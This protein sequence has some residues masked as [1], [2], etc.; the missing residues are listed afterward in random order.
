MAVLLLPVDRLPDHAFMTASQ[1]VRILVTA[2]GSMSKGRTRSNNA[3]TRWCAATTWASMPAQSL[4]TPR[5]PKP[6]SSVPARRTAKCL[7]AW[8]T[9]ARWVTSWKPPSIAFTITFE[10]QINKQSPRRDP[11]VI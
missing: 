10:S 4:Q 9:W 11:P 1:G 2:L 5:S 3:L 7:G 8:L 6:Q